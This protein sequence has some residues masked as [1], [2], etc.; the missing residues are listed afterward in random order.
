M[1][2]ASPT[3]CPYHGSVVDALPQSS[4]QQG[5]EKTAGAEE[6]HQQRGRFHRQTWRN[7]DSPASNIFQLAQRW[8]IVRISDF[9]WLEDWEFTSNQ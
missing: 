6:G 8:G 4:T 7:P 1:H 2:S 5:P 3:L 9:F